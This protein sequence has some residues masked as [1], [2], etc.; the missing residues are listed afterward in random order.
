M[1]PKTHLY[2]A[3]F[4]SLGLCSLVVAKFSDEPSARFSSETALLALP[5]PT[6]TPLGLPDQTSELLDSIPSPPPLPQ[7]EPVEPAQPPLRV[8][9]LKVQRGQSLAKIFKTHSIPA[10]DI[11]LLLDSKPL[12]PRL[13]NIYPGHDMRFEFAPDDTLVKLSYSPGPLERIEFERAGDAFNGSEVL[14]EPERFTAYKHGTIEHSLFIASQR[15]GLEDSLTM[16]LAQMF[17]WDV[18]FV[19]DI[20]KGDAFHVVYEELFLEDRFIGYGNI[21][22]AEFVN[23]GQSFQALLYT[24]A[25]GETDYY[26]PNGQSMR[27]AFLRAPVEFSRI[28]S[29]FNLRR[30]HPLYKRVMPH[31]GIDY[32]A[33]SGT[34]ILAAGDGRVK[35]ASR[36]GANGNFV[37]IN[38]GE[39]YVT[40][41]LH[42]SKF[43]RNV[44]S[45]AK[46]KQ[47][48]V[49]GYVGATGA[50]TGPHL[51]YEFLVNGVHVN[52]R[53]VNLPDAAPVAETERDRFSAH[54]IDMLALLDQFKEQPQLALAD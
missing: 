20:R 17:Q 34:P 26:N 33:P 46:V 7:A 14:R 44:K 29:N 47:G 16:R 40:K 54:T 41:Y 30:K 38:H 52:P 12:G 15:A 6:T 45:G 49:I 43:A 23:Q 11:A 10:R 50:A 31:R 2:L 5:A 53:S 22:A 36:T 37:V 51:H 42:L 28:S 39:Q 25:D 24:D 4:L 32:A 1:F 27:K 9:D 35:A 19:L 21:L 3:G 8:V 13:K 18:D 48:Q